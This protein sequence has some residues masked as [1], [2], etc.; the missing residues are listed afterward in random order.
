GALLALQG[1]HAVIEQNL[2]VLFLEAGHLGRHLDLL[3]A[4]GDLDARP[5]SAP[6]GGEPAERRQ[7]AVK[8]AENIVEQAV[9]LAMQRQEGVAIV[10]AEN[11][12]KLVAVVAAPGDQITYAHRFSPF[13]S[14]WCAFLQS[15]A[16]SR[17]RTSGS[18]EHHRG[19][20][21]RPA[22]RPRS[23]AAPPSAWPLRC[24]CRSGAASSLRESRA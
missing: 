7:T 10:I 17:T 3:L 4:V 20:L 15:S 19:L 14:S 2:D 24:R 11:A 18:W 6:E 12:W 9:H 5:A 16:A 21:R 23:C 1:Q 8:A 13:M 22:L